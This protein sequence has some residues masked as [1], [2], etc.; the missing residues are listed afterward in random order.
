MA[1]DGTLYLAGIEGATKGLELWKAAFMPSISIV[2]PAR[3]VTAGNQPLL[4]F[5][6]MKPLADVAVPAGAKLQEQAYSDWGAK[7]GMATVHGLDVDLALATCTPRIR[8]RLC[9]RLRRFRQ[10]ARQARPR[11]GPG[12]RTSQ[13][14]GLFTCHLRGWKDKPAQRPVSLLKFSARDGRQIARFDFDQPA[15]KREPAALDMR[16]SRRACGSPTSARRAAS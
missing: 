11:A 10:A 9:G 2:P 13:D 1:P 6:Q 16:R 4:G 14:G 3:P 15:K 7:M 5:L 12:G 8:E